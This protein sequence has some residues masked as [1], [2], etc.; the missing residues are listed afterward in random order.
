MRWNARS[1]SASRDDHAV[2]PAVVVGPASGVWVMCGKHWRVE[3]SSLAHPC[4]R[5][6]PNASAIEG[7]VRASPNGSVPVTALSRPESE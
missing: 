1:G 6:S 2:W 3:G 7:A 5:G 4:A